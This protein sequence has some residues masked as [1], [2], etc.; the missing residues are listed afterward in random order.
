MQAS[1]MTVKRDWTAARAWLKQQMQPT[2]ATSGIKG[3]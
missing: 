1:P 3:Y 2:K